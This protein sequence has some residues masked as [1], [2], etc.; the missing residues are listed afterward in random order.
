MG[1]QVHSVS[2]KGVATKFLLGGGGKTL[3]SKPH[4]CLGWHKA[5][6]EGR[7]FRSQKVAT[8]G[9]DKNFCFKM[10]EHQVT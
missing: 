10:G 7:L 8:R 3:M 5:I 6:E 2:P 9:S 1:H 4:W